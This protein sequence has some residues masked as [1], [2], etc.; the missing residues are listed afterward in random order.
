MNEE[1]MMV[2]YMSEEQR[3]A[4]WVRELVAD[5]SVDLEEYVAVLQEVE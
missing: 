3:H 4:M 5:N 1:M 2:K